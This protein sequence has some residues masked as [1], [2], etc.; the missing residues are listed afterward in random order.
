MRT[1]M[2]SFPSSALQESPGQGAPG[3]GMSAPLEPSR[4]LLP[5]IG[6][7]PVLRSALKRL[8]LSVVRSPT[9]SGRADPPA[10]HPFLY[11]MVVD[12]S[13]VHAYQA[14]I[15]LFTLEEFGGVPRERIVVQCT[16][17]VSDEV[18]GAFER[19]GYSTASFPPYLDETYCNK[20]ARLDYF[21]EHADASANGVFLLDLD[22]AVL[23]ALEVPDPNVVWGKVVDGPNPP[24]E[25]LERLFSAAGLDLPG[26]VPCDWRDAGPTVV[27]NMN[28]GFLYVP[29]ALLPRL[30]T[31]WR[32]WAEYLFSRPD[33]IDDPRMRI[34][35]DQISFSM[36]LSSERIP[37]S[38]LTANW[39]FPSHD[40][41]HPRSFRSEEDLHVIHYHW[42][43]DAFG[44]IAPAYSGNDAFDAAVE[45]VNTAIGSRG[46][47][48]FF[49]MYKRHLAR[50][51]VAR[52]P[53]TSKQVFSRGFVARTR[54]GD[55][56]RRMILHGG[57]SKT[58]TSS[59][60]HCLG[61]NRRTLAEEGWWYPPPSIPSP[62][63]H[64]RLVELLRS[65]DE[66]AFVEYIETALDDM[67]EHAHTII[68]TTEGIFNHWWDYPPKAKGLLRHLAA[69]FDFEL[70]VWFRPPE[71]FAVA[72]YIQ[73]LGNPT[74]EDTPGNVYGKDVD[75]T[76]AMQ[77]G[78]FR[79][80]L[81][82]LGFYYEAQELFGCG[83]VKALPYAGDTVRAFLDRYR[84]QRL[85]TNDCRHNVSMR[86]SGVDMM[87][88]VNR[89]D[90]DGIDRHRVVDLVLE[91]DGI[92]GTRA[93][94]FRLSKAERNLVVGHA[95]RGWDVLRRSFSSPGSDRR[96]LENARYRNKVFC[97]GFGKSGTRTM[98]AALGVLGY[99]VGEQFGVRDPDIGTH[100]LGTALALATEF[101]AFIGNPWTVL[102]RELD[103]TFPGSRFILT[104]RPAE[105]WI[106]S[107]VSYF[108]DESTPMRKWIYGHGSPCGN[109]DAYLMRYRRHIRA[110][111][112]YFH[113]REEDFLVMELEAGDGW[114]KLCGF[115]G[116]PLPHVPFPHLNRGAD[117]PIS[118]ME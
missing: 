57:T 36:A 104:V 15:L 116:C 25:V 56:K 22:L 45:R 62:P 80:H 27:T 26:V 38:H 40:E 74:T 35:I 6:P 77:D 11:S 103:A 60:Q 16:D 9:K 79:R 20:I 32:R 112:A 23:T 117:R 47:S 75:F 107:A 82:Y 42:N 24:L 43:L 67:P 17:R 90:L 14:E 83:R 48:V 61:A 92:I 85:S 39:N 88:M 30:R 113:G 96:D 71:D 59:L 64:Q 109:E 53:V 76:A 89:F 50:Q 97:I 13:P 106:A 68:L 70:C 2:R 29:R 49:D 101:D 3:G 41:K 46:E 94:R 19:S 21:L 66:E 100:A 34:H 52:V 98:G 58:G 7:F 31:G 12:W 105:R 4:S 18:R 63:K 1:R 44:L 69:L 108:G 111:A 5:R 65:A 102:Y 37:F 55:R 81:D 91:I 73:S 87:R 8:L 72:Y 86:S 114:E 33:L 84:I 118:H 51:S 115:L 95:R 78:W 28:G 99:R 54:I 93:E 10:D 110:V